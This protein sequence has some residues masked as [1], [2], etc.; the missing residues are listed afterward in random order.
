[1]NQFLYF[2]LSIFSLNANQ[3]YMN[4]YVITGGPGSGKS[5][6]IEALRERG[7][8]CIEEAGRQ[9]IQEQLRIGGDAL[10]W[11]DIVRFKELMLEHALKTYEEAKGIK[12]PAFFD[13]GVVDLIG[14]DTLTNAKSTD[15]LLQAV[16]KL[17]YNSK[18]FIAPPWEAIYC[19]DAERKQTFEEAIAT[20]NCIKKAYLDEGYDIIELPLK[21]VEERIEFIINTID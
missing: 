6:L 21:S 14:Y 10:P 13:R 4:F 20:Y 11:A 18:V 8:V 17:R 15:K 9:I 2:L 12:G 19:N 7:Y 16:K 5:T 1:M 3:I